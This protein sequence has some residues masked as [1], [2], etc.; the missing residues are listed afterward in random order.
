[1]TASPVHNEQR[2]KFKSVVCSIEHC[3]MPDV[4]AVCP[5]LVR[6]TA[7]KICCLI[8]RVVLI[9][10]DQ[11]ISCVDCEYNTGN[12]SSVPSSDDINKVEFLRFVKKNHG[13]PILLS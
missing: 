3:G 9:F 11:F 7:I 13:I 2:T 6:S 4:M 10:G 12:I 1:M 8:L 5:Y